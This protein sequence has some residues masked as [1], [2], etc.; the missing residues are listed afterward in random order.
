MGAPGL[1]LCIEFATIAAQWAALVLARIANPRFA[2]ALNRS[3][4]TWLVL[5]LAQFVICLAHSQTSILTRYWNQYSSMA[6]N[7]NKMKESSPDSSLNEETN[8][9]SSSSPQKVPP[10]DD[11]KDQPQRGQHNW[12]NSN[13]P[14]PR[15][16]QNNQHNYRFPRRHF[17]D[18]SQSRTEIKKAVTD[19]FGS[20]CKGKK[21]RKEKGKKKRSQF[22]G[23]RI[24]GTVRSVRLDA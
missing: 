4:A 6:P 18:D 7:L 23:A 1:C 19:M 16:K 3:Q 8:V 15:K 5:S 21:F 10:A 17:A 12:Q 14:Y 24:D 11:N 22:S 20:G 9:E 2:F 13:K